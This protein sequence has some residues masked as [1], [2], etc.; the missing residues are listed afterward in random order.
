MKVAIVTI[1]AA[2]F[3]AGMYLCFQQFGV[4]LT[5]FIMTVA[6]L[7]VWS[8]LFAVAICWWFIYQWYLSHVGKKY[9]ETESKDYDP[10]NYLSDDE[11]GV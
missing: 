7:T 5:L 4:V 1:I 11:A 9:A 6:L 10:N 2:I 8:S 3:I